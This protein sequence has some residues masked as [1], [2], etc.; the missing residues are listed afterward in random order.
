MVKTKRKKPTYKTPSGT[1]E[2]H[3]R[4]YKALRKPVQLYMFEEQAI[5]DQLQKTEG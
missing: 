5:K 3:L 1:A 2:D 4:A